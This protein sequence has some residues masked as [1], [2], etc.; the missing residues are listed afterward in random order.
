MHAPAP[1]RLVHVGLISMAV[2]VAG[3]AI[4]VVSGHITSTTAVTLVFDAALLAAL[5]L[6]LAVIRRIDVRV[7]QL[8]RRNDRSVKE[9]QRQSAALSVKLGKLGE[10]VD[11]SRELVSRDVFTTYQ[12]VEAVIDLRE[13][14]RAAL[15]R[16]STR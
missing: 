8:T 4:L 1:R 2:V 9:N 16:P 5:A 13:L 10:R 15:E 7:D 12:Q 6:T 11:R 3:T 14:I